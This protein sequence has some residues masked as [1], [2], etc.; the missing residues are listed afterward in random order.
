M[1]TKL[2]SREK[3]V[4]HL[5][6]RARFTRDWLDQTPSVMRFDSS[7]LLRMDDLGEIEELESLGEYW[8]RM[9]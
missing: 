2:G 9:M 6:G 7:S 4:L 8:D 1:L 3:R 5:A